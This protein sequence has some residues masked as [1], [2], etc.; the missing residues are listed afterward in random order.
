MKIYSSSITYSSKD[1]IKKSELADYIPYIDLSAR[2]PIIR[3]YTGVPVNI[4]HQTKSGLTV[5][6][7]KFDLDQDNYRLGA[8]FDNVKDGDTVE[9]YAYTE[10][11]P[12]FV[13]TNTPG[14]GKYYYVSGRDIVKDAIKYVADIHNI[15]NFLY[16]KS[17]R[18][19]KLNV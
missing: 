10:F 19:Y 16:S 7:C 1:L 13:C 18:Y 3:F 4:I 2:I 6:R 12:I 11:T 17:N 8:Y 15:D 5:T 9:L 14:R